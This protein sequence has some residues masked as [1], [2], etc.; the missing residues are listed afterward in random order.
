MPCSESMN[1]VLQGTSVIIAVRN[2]SEN[3]KQ[4]I[5]S[6]L[7]NEIKENLYEIIIVDDH[8]TD[9]TLAKIQNF[10]NDNIRFIQQK[11][12]INGKKA[13][14]TLGISLAKFPI[15]ICTDADSNVGKNWIETHTLAYH[16]YTVKFNTGIV[17]PEMNETILS[18]FQWLDFAATMAI[19]ANGIY[20]QSYFLANGANLS[21][22]KHTF[23]K[24]KGFENIEILASGD[25]VFLASK[26]AAQ[27]PES[28]RF[29]KS[30]NAI[31][32]TKAEANWS[33]FFAQR[34]RWATKSM[35][36]GNSKVIYIQSFV[37]VFSVAL[38]VGLILSITAFHQALPAVL[39]ALVLKMLTDYLFLDQLTNY[40]ENKKVMKYFIP[41]FFIYFGHIIISGYFALFPSNYSWK[42]RRTK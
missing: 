27:Y 13:A 5:Q 34:K 15:I 36:S 7:D 6:I 4:C 17:L 19:T 1:N 29:L 14:L 12:G 40:F 42:G 11:E 33:S 37:F 2:E 26:I 3:I 16:D 32:H 38:M 30:K 22:Q 20:R 41:C 18:K 10:H 35:Q 28:V 23:D 39:L 24:V 21:Y 25:D 9:D 31:V 8:S